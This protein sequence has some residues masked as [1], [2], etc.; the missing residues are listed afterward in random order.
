MKHTKKLALL[1]FLLSFGSAQAVTI[2]IT[3]AANS[4]DVGSSDIGTFAATELIDDD[5]ANAASAADRTMTYTISG[6]T[7]DADGT[8]NDSVTVNLVVT[9]DGQNIQTSGAMQAGWLASGDIT[10]N[11]NGEQL[12]IGFGS[13][14]SVLSGGGSPDSLTFNGF[15]AVSWGSWAS[16]HVAVVNGVSNAYDDGNVGNE[17]NKLQTV[18]GNSLETVFDSAANTGAAQDADG[19]WRPEGWDFS[20]T[21]TAVPEPGTSALFG[22]GGMILLLRRRK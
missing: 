20:V 9:T 21:V 11:A 12:T 10:M 2:S 4:T 6:L 14:S 13:I 1:V 15:S 22:L 5:T 8:A 7:I 16:G 18:S 3:G 19:S 17:F